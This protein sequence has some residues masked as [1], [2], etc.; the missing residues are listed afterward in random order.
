ML[1]NWNLDADVVM[2]GD[3][4]STCGI[5]SRI[6]TKDTHQ[7]IVLASWGEEIKQCL[8]ILECDEHKN[9]RNK[10]DCAIC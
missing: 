10:K 1:F 3:K 9:A 5:A 8:S 7:E 4:N 6:R 2:N